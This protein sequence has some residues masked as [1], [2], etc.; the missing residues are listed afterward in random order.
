VNIKFELKI[1]SGNAALAEDPASEV[2]RIMRDLADKMCAFP[3]TPGD[4][5]FFALRDI[6]GNA[7]GSAQFS[8]EEDD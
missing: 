4:E 3:P 5:L 7:V 2:T 6:N 1:N 8:I